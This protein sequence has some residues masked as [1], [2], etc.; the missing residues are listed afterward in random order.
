LKL[1]VHLTDR[2]VITF[3]D[4]ADRDGIEI[5]PKNPDGIII[6]DSITIPV[7]AITHVEWK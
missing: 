6:G 2:K 1:I 3:P 7:R 5:V 4:G